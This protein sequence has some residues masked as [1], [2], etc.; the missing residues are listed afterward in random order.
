[1]IKVGR[2]NTLKAKFIKSKV[3]KY[4]PTLKNVCYTKL[5]NYVFLKSK[6]KTYEIHTKQDKESTNN[7]RHLIVNLEKES[8]GITL[9]ERVKL[10]LI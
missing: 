3:R 7:N 8:N 5:R 4:E 9:G 2:R 6:M 1:M 10:L